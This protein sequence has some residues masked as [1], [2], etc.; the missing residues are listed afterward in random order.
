M[1]GDQ[2]VNAEFWLGRASNALLLAR[3]MDEPRARHAMI[4]IARDYAQRARPADCGWRMSPKWADLMVQAG[5]DRSRERTSC[6]RSAVAFPAHA[7]KALSRA[8]DIA[9]AAIAPGITSA[10][11]GRTRS[12]LA[13]ALVAVAAADSS[14]ALALAKAALEA[15]DRN[16]H[17]ARRRREM[18]Q[19][20]ASHYA[21]GLTGASV[22]G[23]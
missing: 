4:G 2:R 13:A 12:Q 19:L 18:P 9:W 20:S 14:D 22:K 6:G 11:V 7:V 23:R 1:V 8:F 10:Q 16:G 3:Q 21:I 15:L 17:N 5:A